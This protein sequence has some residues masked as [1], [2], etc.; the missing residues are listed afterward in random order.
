VTITYTV[1]AVTLSINS[2]SPEQ[3]TAGGGPF[4]LTVF[5]SGFGATSIVTW[6]GATL[7]TNYMSSTTLRASVSASQ[8]SSVGTASIAVVN[9]A[10]SGGTSGTQTI[11]IVAP[12][13]D[14]VSYQMN[15]AHTGSVTFNNASLPTSS[16]WSVNVGGSPSYA[17][18]IGGVVYVTVSVNGGSQLLA[19]NSTNGATLWG[20]IAFS[21]DA[22]AT[23][24]DGHLFV[25]SNP[26]SF[27]GQ[28][29]EAL[30]A[31]TGTEQWISAAPGEWDNAPPVALDGIVYTDNTGSIMAFD[32]NTGA[33][34]W[35]GA[36]NGTNGTVALTVDGAYAA[37]PC[38]ARIS[39]G[40]RHVALVQ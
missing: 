6:N 5:G 39:A 10:D 30:D 37:A 8:I 12:T 32:E 34:L 13:L 11:S 29:I 27:G 33:M 16:T 18:I 35:Q 26:G 1:T 40:R 14:A 36:S 2:L 24:D 22:N 7:P 20:P 17:L 23:Y 28:I 19:L 21:G 25:V 31:T 9:P 38:T 15:A 3:V 4:T